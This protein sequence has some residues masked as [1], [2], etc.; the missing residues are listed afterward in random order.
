MTGGE[1]GVPEWSTGSPSSKGPSIGGLFGGV[2]SPIFTND[3]DLRRFSPNDFRLCPADARENRNW[4]GGY[5]TAD[6]LPEFQGPKYRGS[7]R[8]GDFADR[9]TDAPG[10][11]WRAFQRRWARPAI[12]HGVKPPLFIRGGRV[13]N[14][15]GGVLLGEGG[16]IGDRNWRGGYQTADRLPEFQGPKYRGSFRRGDFAEEGG[17]G[18]EG[19]SKIAP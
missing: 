11:G 17:V 4:R 15:E 3:F 9:Q 18:I 14:C 19:G 6:R 2:T 10:P 1:G 13:Q 12:I 7:F 16:P 5:Q 8:R